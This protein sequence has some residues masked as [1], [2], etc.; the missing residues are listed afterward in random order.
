VILQKIFA[1][2]THEY[3]YEEWVALIKG[4]PLNAELRF[5]LL[6]LIDK[7][8]NSR[9]SQLADPISIDQTQKNE[10]LQVISAILGKR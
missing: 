2:P 1:I 8:E 5:S 4:Q 10:T 6:S 3:S 7:L 9:F